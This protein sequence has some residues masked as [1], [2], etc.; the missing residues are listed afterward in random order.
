M[1]P[2]IQLLIGFIAGLIAMFFLRAG[3]VKVARAAEVEARGLASDAQNAAYAA[4][5][6]LKKLK[7]AGVSAIE[8]AGAAAAQQ[9]HSA[10]E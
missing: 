1:T 8:Q 5:D 7:N 6:E 3:A 4:Q 10:P 9:L 2:V